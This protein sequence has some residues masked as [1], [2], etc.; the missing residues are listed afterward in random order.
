MYSN[1][2][3]L[4]FTSCF[5]EELLMRN[6]LDSFTSASHLNQ[7]VQNG[8]QASVNAISSLTAPPLITSKHTQITEDL[9]GLE[10]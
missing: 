4:L 5:S 2:V 1:F 9:Q 7:V 10:L 3:A 8:Q 6:F